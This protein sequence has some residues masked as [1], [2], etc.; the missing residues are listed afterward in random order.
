LFRFPSGQTHPTDLHISWGDHNIWP[1]TD[2]FGSD[3]ATQIWW[4][5]KANGVDE[6][7]NQ[8]T[9]MWEYSRAGKRYL[10]GE[11]PS[12]EP[13]VF[14]PATSIIQ[15]PTLPPADQPPSYPSPAK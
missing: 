15:Y 12:G 7:G 13:D 1:T 3:D 14:N 5:P 6:V 10:P 11:W 2:L 4:N 9:G 8:G